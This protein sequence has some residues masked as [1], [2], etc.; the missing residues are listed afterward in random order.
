MAV[1]PAIRAIV[2]Q[3]IQTQ[4]NQ[5]P[6]TPP[7]PLTAV[8]TTEVLQSLMTDEAAVAEM[9]T[10]LPP[11]QQTSEDLREALGSPQLQQSL[12][13]LTQAI[14]SDQLPVLFSSLGLDPTVIASAQPGTDA[15]ELLIRA[16]EGSSA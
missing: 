14:H 1:D 8:L 16:M 4:G 5:G 13:G 11:G 2:Q 3:F 6:R 12:T 9:S 7:V 15:L 10:L